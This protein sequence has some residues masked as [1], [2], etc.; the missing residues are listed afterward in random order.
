MAGGVGGKIH[1]VAD[2]NPR[3]IR[4]VVGLAAGLAI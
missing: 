4:G 2:E 1:E 3:V